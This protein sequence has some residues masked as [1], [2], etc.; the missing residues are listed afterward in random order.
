MG[1]NSAFKSLMVTVYATKFN[2]KELC[3][4]PWKV[5]FCTLNLRTNSHH[6]LAQDYFISSNNRHELCLL[7]GT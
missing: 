4:L 3:V 2:I 6:F 1:F 5:F 7:R